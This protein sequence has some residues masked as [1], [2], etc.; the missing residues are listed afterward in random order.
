NGANTFFDHQ[1]GSFNANSPAWANNW[2][3]FRNNDMEL[4]LQYHHPVSI[5]SVSL[6]LLIETE[7][8]I[9]PPSSVEIWGGSS[10]AD[11]RLMSRHQTQ[12]PD[13]YRKPYIQLM[14]YE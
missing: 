2:G 12:L 6:N 10:P 9:F 3:G 11:L 4:L 8:S 1:L 13:V 7:N 14:D 5:S